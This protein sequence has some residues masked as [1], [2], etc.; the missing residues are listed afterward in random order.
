MEVVKLN[1]KKCNL[2]EDLAQ[3]RSK[4]RNK[5]C[6]AD[7]NIVGTWDKALMIMMMINTNECRKG[8]GAR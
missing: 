2:S 4:W 6:V 1:I 3:D 7:P 5:I 8:Y